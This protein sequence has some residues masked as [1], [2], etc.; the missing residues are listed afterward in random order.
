MGPH[1]NGIGL[2]LLGGIA[3]LLMTTAAVAL[4]ASWL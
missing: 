2:N 1:R 4:V 3:A